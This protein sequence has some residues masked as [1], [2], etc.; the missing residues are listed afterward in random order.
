MTVH[1]FGATSSPSC[2]NFALRTT[3]EVGRGDF[4]D[5]VIDTVLRNF[6]VD[7]C[8]K[9]VKTVNEGIHMVKNLRSLLH[10]GGFNIVKWISND[11]DVVRSIPLVSR[12][13]VIKDMDLDNQNLPIE[14]ALGI[15]WCV[16][17]DKFVFR[18]SVDERP[19]TRRGIL[20]MI[21]SVY[22]PLGFLA[23]FMLR[24]KLLLQEL[25]KLN[26]GWDE[27]IPAEL[28]TQWTKWFQDLQELSDFTVRR[29][30]KPIGYDDVMQAELHHFSDAS[31]KGYG[32]VSYLRFVDVNGNVQC[33]FVIGKSRVCPLKQT[34]IPRLELT[35]ATVAVRTKQTFDR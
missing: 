23:P 21:S 35:A 32:V 28:E 17:M 5:S 6:Y 33:S 4:D 24:A 1:I 2:V 9:S 29:C 34:T 3:A 22:D 14:R 12:A 16:E 13:E 31:E 18:I 20:S 19:K 30:Y 7:D 15:S 10:R 26:L 8:L 27:T 11:R 25:C